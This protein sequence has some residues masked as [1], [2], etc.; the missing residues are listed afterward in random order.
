MKNLCV[1]L[2]G[3]LGN[4]FFEYATAY[5][6]AKRWN[7]KLRMDIRCPSFGSGHYLQYRLNLV[8][9]SA[10]PVSQQL[11]WKILTSRKKQ[12]RPL[13]HA[14]QKLAG[15]VVF[16]ETSGFKKDARLFGAVPEGR[17]LYLNGYWQT[18]RYFEECR[19]EL[20]K[21]FSFRTEPAGKNLEILQQIQNTPGA[22]SLHIRRGDYLNIQ[23]SIA[24]PFSYYD[25]AIKMI[26][27]KINE[28]VFFVFSDDIPWAESNLQGKGRFVFVDGNGVDS[29]HEDMRL[30]AACK[31]HIIAN[32]SFS[33]WG[34]W[35]NPSEEK[36]V[37]APKYW[38]IKKETFYPDLFPESW[39]QINNLNEPA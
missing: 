4:Q 1:K 5:A 36:T 11:S 10:E 8:N 35:L 16:D 32:S 33:W 39:M 13:S 7:L 12:I 28:P 21:E 23:G 14:I 19:A 15:I 29:A 6:L 37:I 31:H 3:G 20:L 26:G 27:E 17:T 38:M 34:A 2:A 9:I 24:L 30:M 25:R 18:P 22:V